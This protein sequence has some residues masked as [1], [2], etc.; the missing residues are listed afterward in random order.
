MDAKAFHN[1]KLSDSCSIHQ[2]AG[3]KSLIEEN[4]KHKLSYIFNQSLL[5]L[6]FTYL[7]QFF[8]IL[9]SPF[10]CTRT[11]GKD[12]LWPFKVRLDQRFSKVL[13]IFWSNKFSSPEVQR[14]FQRQKLPEGR[15]LSF[16][17]TNSLK[18]VDSM[19]L[20]VEGKQT[21][22]EGVK[23]W[24]DEVQHVVHEAEDLLDLDDILERLR[25]LEKRAH[26]LC[27]I[28]CP[29]RRLPCSSLMEVEFGAEFLRSTIVLLVQQ[30]GSPIEFRGSFR[31]QILNEGLSEKFK[32]PLNAIKIML[33]KAETKQITNEDVKSWLQHATDAVYEAANL[34]DDIVLEAGRAELK[35]S[36]QSY[37]DKIQNVFSARCTSKKNN[38]EG[39]MDE[40]LVKIFGKLEILA[41]EG[42]NRHN[43]LRSDGPPHIDTGVC[44]RDYDKETI[45]PLL[46]SEDAKGKSLETIV[47]EGIGGIGK[48]SFAMLVYHDMKVQECFDLK[49]WVYISQEFD[50]VRIVVDILKNIGSFRGVTMDP[51]EL[52]QELRKRL[53][54]NKLLLV[55]D[56][57]WKADDQHAQWNFLVTALESA[58]QGSKIIITTR[59]M[60]LVVTSVLPCVKPFNLKEI[61]DD[62]CWALFS[63]H[64]FC[65]EGSQARLL[66][67]INFRS[68]VLGRC[69]GVPLRAIML[70]N[71]LRCK[72]DTYWEEISSR[73]DLQPG[74][75]S[76]YYEIKDHAFKREKTVLLW[77]A[78]GF[79]GGDK[80]KKE[81]GNGYFQEL[82]DYSFFQQKSDNTSSYFMKDLVHSWA[83]FLRGEFSVSLGDGDSRVSPKTRH[84]WCPTIRGYE[85]LKNLVGDGFHIF[86]T[87]LP[88]SNESFWGDVNDEKL[89]AFNRLRVLSLSNIN[90]L[91]DVLG[92]L[93]HLRHLEIS[94]E[95]IK[96]LP[97]TLCMLFTLQTLILRQCPNLAEL[98]ANI[99][100]LTELCHLDIRET[101]LQQT[102]PQMGKLKKL[103]T[104]TDFFVGQQNGCRIDELGELRYLLGDLRIMNLQNVSHDAIEADLKG[105]NVKKLELRW[106]GRRNS[107]DSLAEEDVLEALKPS[108]KV[109]DISITGFGGKK[110]PEWLGHTSFENLVYLRL[111][112]CKYCVSLPSLGQLESLRTLLIEG[113]Y[114]LESV[115][116]EF[117][118]SPTT[119]GNPFQSLESLTFERMLQWREWESKGRAFPSLQVLCIRKCPSLTTLP[120]DLPSLVELE[121][122]K[123]KLVGLPF[124]WSPATIKR[125]MLANDF[126]KLQLEKSVFDSQSLTVD[127]FHAFDFIRQEIENWGYACTALQKIDITRCPLE[128]FPLNLFPQLKQLEISRCRKLKSLCGPEEPLVA[129]QLWKTLH[130]H[131]AQNFESL[132]CSLPSLENLKIVA[133]GKLQSLPGMDFS[134][135]LEPL[136]GNSN[137]NSEVCKYPKLKILSLEHCS[138]FESLFCSLPS[139][140]N[141][142][143]VASGKLQSLPGMG[144]YTSLEPLAGSNWNSE[145]CEYPKLKLLSLEQCSN[146]ESLLCSLPSLENLKVVASGKLQSLPGMGFSTSLEPLA[147]SNWNSEVCEYP[148]LKLLS[149]EHCSNFESLLC[150]LPSLE[151]LKIVA[152][153]K[154][155]SLPGMGF[156][157]SLEPLAGSNWNSEVCKYPKLKILSLEHCSNFESLLCSLPSLENL[158]VVA[159]GKLQSLPGMGFSPSLEPL[160]GS[161]WNSEV[162]EYPNLK[163]L[164]LEHCS[165]LKTVHGL[166]PSLEHLELYDCGHLEPFLGMGFSSSSGSSWPSKLKSIVIR[167]C[168]KLLAG[169]DIWAWVDSLLFQPYR[170]SLELQGLTSLYGLELEDCP[171]LQSLS[172]V[173]LPSDLF[174]LYIRSCPFL[175]QRC[176]Q[177]TGEDWPKISNVPNILI[178]YHDFNAL[179]RQM[180]NQKFMDYYKYID[181]YGAI[182]G[183]CRTFE[184]ISG[185]N[186]SQAHHRQSLSPQRKL[187]LHRDSFRRSSRPPQSTIFEEPPQSSLL[188]GIGRSTSRHRRSDATVHVNNSASL[189]TF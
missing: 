177:D 161:N 153:G 73:W 136:A 51:N 122:A 130:Y 105:K 8:F 140:E 117:Y 98:P 37:P 7:L 111:C 158:K 84:I 150:S 3:T 64:A 30:L 79:L 19:L 165:N 48:T 15:R 63:E 184:A 93:K 85:D 178:G 187:S 108:A 119:K 80:G 75:Y 94:G 65:G 46:I 6:P 151:N 28:K 43:L 72:Q 149:L 115:G 16:K 57:V 157:T 142:K 169:C 39:K 186:R 144:F 138:N 18:S 66:S 159:S 49:A 55:L 35:S 47:V 27:L 146:F 188:I 114:N 143:I 88:I 70:G 32:E 109:E 2:T 170:T 81:E 31:S 77:L 60:S 121:I 76:C 41:R 14:F 61:S 89:K 112:G 110:L 180:L 173:S 59:E 26:T 183:M 154:L 67:D 123:C 102:P 116:D 145:V 20:V 128:F 100:N 104:L 78:N 118:G 156:S 163:I 96:S 24:L 101:G 185:E 99:V 22:K 164:S 160:A 97:E 106:S 71:H 152:F 56:E 25:G 13:L 86:R 10:F 132:F 38:K 182:A 135:S 44:G 189:F 91:P 131:I 95:S 33:P 148:N 179:R 133:S 124:G 36:T 58:A 50:A 181:Y 176:Q 137:W 34:L 69:G 166:L 162:C 107:D 172:E 23:D 45:M 62:D 52:Q 134:A 92:W 103:E 11:L 4:S 82:V 29:K 147:D 42:E 120:S 168:R 113:F 90:R 1:Q 125:I 83:K 74:H 174:Y 175:E 17:L 53:T 54:G 171:K 139:L 12:S 9:L 126:H 129:V 68:K 87:I 127:S 155:Q 141:L 40:N 167:G 5:S 21:T